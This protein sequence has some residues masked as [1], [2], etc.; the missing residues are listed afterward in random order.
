MYLLGCLT[1]FLSVGSAVFGVSLGVRR[2]RSRSSDDYRNLICLCKHGLNS[3]DP[4]DP[5][6]P[7][8]VQYIEE[9]NLQ[10]KWIKC[11]CRRYLGPELPSDA[12]S[13]LMSLVSNPT[14]RQITDA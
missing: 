5:L 2:Y 12:L 9:V 3:H 8:M 6:R 10:D 7:C 14:T 1:G 11:A 4:E 13:N